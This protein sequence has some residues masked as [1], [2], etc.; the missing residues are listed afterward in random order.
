[1]QQVLILQ[2]RHIKLYYNTNT[3][4]NCPQAIHNRKW[5]YSGLNMRG[6]TKKGPKLNTLKKSMGQEQRTKKKS[7]EQE[8]LIFVLST[9]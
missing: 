3:L 5:G 6:I 7:A 1:M 8:D 2:S 9:V 4:K